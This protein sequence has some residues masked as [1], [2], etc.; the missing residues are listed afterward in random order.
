MT[1]AL[2]PRYL[3]GPEVDARFGIS[4]TTRR[5]WLAAGFM[6]QPVRFGGFPSWDGPAQKADAAST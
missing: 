5:R 1:H 3:T 4:R 6:P 2:K